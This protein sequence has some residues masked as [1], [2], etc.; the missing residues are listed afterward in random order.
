M[1]GLLGARILCPGR[2]ACLL[3]AVSVSQHNNDLVQSFWPAQSRVCTLLGN[4]VIVKFMRYLANPQSSRYIMES[5]VYST[6]IYA[7]SFQISI[8]LTD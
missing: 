4:I 7:F 1:T 2:V 8:L 5:Y 6:G 3:E